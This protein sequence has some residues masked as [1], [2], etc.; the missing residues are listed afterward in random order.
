[1]KPKNYKIMFVF[2]NDRMRTVIP[3][4]ISYLSA[5]LKND[6]FSTYVF[7][8]SFFKEHERLNEERKKEDAGIFK[9]VDYSTIGVCIKTSSLI[10]DLLHTIES[11]SP[12]LIGFSVYSQAKSL[13]IKLAEK[14][15][16]GFPNIPI[17][18]GGIHTNIEPERVLSYDF[19]DYIC[20]G[21]GEEAL[22]EFVNK[23]YIGESVENVQNIGLRKDGKIII[24]PCRPPQ[25]LDELPFLDWECFAPY[26]QFG[27]YR[28]K[29]LKMALVEGTRT[30]PYN[31][32][33]C[34]ILSINNIIKIAGTKSVIG[35]N[36]LYA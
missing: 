35:T 20:L 6:G 32:T 29:L 11:E 22:V 17:I 25:N 5:A 36:H 31:C 33:Y 13:N 14:I 23:M 2:V 15:K 18:F 7:D 19:V 1:V 34:E 8:T 21:E 27:P 28:G 24:N 3:L 26:H 4:N 12:N 10:D 16:N 30:C 9:P